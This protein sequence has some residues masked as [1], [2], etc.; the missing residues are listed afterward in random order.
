MGVARA[1]GLGRPQRSDRSH[2]PDWFHRRRGSSRLHRFAGSHRPHRRNGSNRPGRPPVT[3]QGTWLIGVTY[4]AGDAVFFNGSSYISLSGGNTGNT[5]TAGAPWALLTQQGSTGPAGPTGGSGPTGA[6]G[7][8]GPTGS[9][10]AQ[11]VQGVAGPTGPPIT[12]QNV[13]SNLVTYATGDAVFFTATGSSYISLHASNVNHSPPT[14]PADWALLAQQGAAGASAPPQMFVA[15]FSAPASTSAQFVGL[16]GTN[17]QAVL[18]ST[19]TLM[20]MPAAAS[21]SFKAIYLAGTITASAASDTLTITMI[22][23]GS[24]TALTTQIIVST[25]NATV[26]NSDTTAGHAFSVVAGDQIA[27]QI[28][29]T[30]SSP[31]VRLSVSTYCE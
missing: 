17:P 23:N 4:A 19:A 20:A 11:G 1:A 25:L 31:T 13:W 3:F 5:P 12:F 27:I 15:Q 26:T 21:C 8:A 28:T 22:K 16:N 10:G 6:T 29:Q 18:G 14:S 30:T 7:S 24:A 9:T 2:R